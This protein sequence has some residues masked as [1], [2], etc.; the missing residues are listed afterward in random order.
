MK[1]AI[2]IS[3][4]NLRGRRSSG[5]MVSLLDSTVVLC[6]GHWANCQNWPLELA[7]CNGNVQKQNLNDLE[8]KQGF[9][10][11]AVSRAVQR[12]VRVN[13]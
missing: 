9:V 2:I 12:T 3:L 8:F 6:T 11:A 1:K 5:Q 10:E 13:C 7:A 4:H